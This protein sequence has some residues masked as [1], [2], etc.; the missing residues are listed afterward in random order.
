MMQRQLAQ[1]EVFEDKPDETGI[2][3]LVFKDQEYVR[4]N[5]YVQSKVTIGSSPEADLVLNHQSIAD[6]H[7]DVTVEAGTL[8]LTNYRPNDGLRVNGRSIEK[9]GLKRWDVIDIG[10]FSVVLK[11]N[12]VGSGNDTDEDNRIGRKKSG[13][14][15]LAAK[16]TES[17]NDKAGTFS[18]Y[19]I[20]LKNEYPNDVLMVKVAHRLGSIFGKDP[21][22]V[23]SLLRKKGQVLK[24]GLSIE[25]ALKLKELLETSGAQCILKTVNV[26][27]YAQKEKINSCDHI[28]DDEDDEDDVAASFSLKEKLSVV[29]GSAASKN[30]QGLEIRP[31][32]EIVRSINDRVLDVQYISRGKRYQT[33]TDSGRLKLANIS[34]ANKGYV[35]FPD[36]CQ[37][38][39]FSNGEKTELSAFKV[40]NYLYRKRRR[41][42]RL[43]LAFGESVVVTE[44]LCEYQI[45]HT[46]CSVSPT[47]TVRERET[48]I[49]WHHWAWSAGTHLFL[50]LAACIFF[51]ISM[52]APERE[53]LH[54]VKIDMSQLEAE[55]KQEPEIVKPQPK[56]EP[57]K[58]EPAKKEPE[59]VKPSKKQ[60]PKKVAK[61]SKT[62]QKPA[63]PQK[64]AAP[65][66]HR[67]AGGGFGEGNVQNRNIKQTGLLSLLGDGGSEGP[68]NII[69]SVSNIDA[70][71][72]PGAS[73]R[74]F[75]VGGVKGSLGNGKISISTGEIVQTRGSRQVLRS[76]GAEGPGTVAALE[77]GEIGQKQVKGMVTAKMTRTV[78]VQG[79]MSREMVKRV[80]DQ[81]LEEIQYC[82]ESALM[83]NPAIMGRIVYEW[84]I[85]MSGRVGEVRIASSTVNSHQ[86]HDCIKAAIKSWEFPK[87]VGTE[88]VVSYPFVFDLVGF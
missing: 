64:V 65:S 61:A 79:G 50:V 82:Y 18:K 46:S 84:K 73:G 41:L 1:K 15:K 55:K 69:A 83:E 21:E 49:G 36:T 58:I 11:K 40:D 57:P 47:V 52:K 8:L 14:V 76:A 85:L 7:A 63:S 5:G 24:E 39:L 68:A 27:S 34:N 74:Q 45:R 3:F 86:I 71:E 19:S 12:Y 80:I 75:S 70:V 67:D 59:A 38:Y 32:L 6:I 78:S 77:K 13:K 88:V 23:I 16:K 43:P 42:Y 9:I 30:R 62:L 44:G 37:G 26:D 17:E 22:R 87:P 66:K 25:K 31:Q 29:N 48:D 33:K 72:V 81:H 35:T 28:E 54:F 10:P 51:S 4:L 60:P 56:P 53:N 20:A 2:Q